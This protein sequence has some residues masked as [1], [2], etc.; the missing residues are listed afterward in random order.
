MMAGPKPAALP[1]A[2]IASSNGLMTRLKGTGR[3]SACNQQRR[4]CL[5]TRAET[6]CATYLS[7][8]LGSSAAACTAAC[9]AAAAVSASGSRICASASHDVKP[10]SSMATAPARRIGVSLGRAAG[11]KVATSGKAASRH[12]WTAPIPLRRLRASAVTS[13][14]REGGS[15]CRELS[16]LCVVD[17]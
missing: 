16:F 8:Q 9:A 4:S 10:P 3:A 7:N 12:I 6:C 11:L 15:S 2:S 17:Y 14:A 5:A 13:R 1:S